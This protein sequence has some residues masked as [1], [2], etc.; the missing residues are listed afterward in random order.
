MYE[1]CTKAL[2]LVF[3]Y[4]TKQIFCGFLHVEGN[5]FGTSQ[6]QLQIRGGGDSNIKNGGGARRLA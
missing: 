2:I 4:L 6:K 5:Q 1:R 3:V